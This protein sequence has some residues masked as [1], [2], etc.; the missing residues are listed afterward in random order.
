MR[1]ITYTEARNN[2]AA[3]LDRVAND[4]DVTIITR[5]KAE[6]AVL[7]S[8]KEYESLMETAHLLRSPKNAMRLMNAIEDIEN[9][10]NIVRRELID[11]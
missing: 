8:L 1:A 7:M 2:L 3:E 5:Q 4:Y 6:A 9:R 11:E 10:R